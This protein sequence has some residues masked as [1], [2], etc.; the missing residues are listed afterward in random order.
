MT[1]RHR[2]FLLMYLRTSKV[3]T[4]R[5][6][7]YCQNGDSGQHTILAVDREISLFSASAFQARFAKAPS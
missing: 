5:T 6:N 7:Q 4:A 2:S 1:E 3:Q